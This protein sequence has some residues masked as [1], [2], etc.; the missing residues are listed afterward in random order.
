M[1]SYLKPGEEPALEELL[2]DPILTA[3]MQVDQV[4]LETLQ[5]LLDNVSQR[6][7]Q[8]L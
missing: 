7:E 1:A 2:E 3:L 5:P 6:L 4:S 8:P